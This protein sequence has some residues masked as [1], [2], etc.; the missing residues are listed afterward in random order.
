MIRV[1][2]STWIRE[3]MVSIAYVDEQGNFVL[4]DVF[5]IDSECLQ[6]VCSSLNINAREVLTQIKRCKNENDSSNESKMP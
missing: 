6:D 1:N 2:K 5:I 3:S 4:D